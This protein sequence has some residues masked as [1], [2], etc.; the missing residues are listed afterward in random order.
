MEIVYLDNAATT[1][2][3]DEVLNAM[4]PFLKDEYGN[5]SSI[6]SFGKT[7]KVMLEDTRDEAAEFI[8]ASPKEIFFTGSG[9]ES[10]NFAIK[11]I[12]YNFLNTGKNHI[13]TTAIEHSAV[14]DTMKYLESKFNFHVTYLKTD[15]KGRV[16]MDA[17]ASAVRPETFLI[18]I[19]HSN[20]EIGIINDIRSVS[21]I[22]EG[23][24]VFVHTD[25]VQSIGKTNFNVKDLNV[26][27]AT[28]AAHKI[29]GPKGISALYV[30][31]KTPVDKFIHGGMQERNMR[32]GTE[33]IAAVA[34]F[35]KAIELVK[36]NFERDVS[37]YLTLNNYLTAKLKH[38]FGCSILFNSGTEKSLPNIVNI[39]FDKDKLSFD[40][41]MILIQ[42]DMAGIAVSGGSACT[43]GTHKPSYVL[44]ELGRDKRTALGSVRISFGRSNTLKDL[45]HFIDCLKNIIRTV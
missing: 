38:Q 26:N 24:K 17:L 40:E 44:T 9:T 30:K 27:F 20:N 42:L 11:G 12:A 18:S 3:D 13:I 29:Y 41:E 1:R 43:A 10:N 2:I 39:S 28:I 32:G 8:G 21:D 19:M 31:D 45:D 4:M 25:S 23:G 35:R 14:L 34:G 6:H 7:A 22:A 5:A 37:H 16:S 15:A 33:N 36:N